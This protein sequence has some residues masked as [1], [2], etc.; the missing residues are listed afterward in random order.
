MKISV[1]AGGSIAE[2]KLR[3]SDAVAEIALKG[4]FMEPHPTFTSHSP[5]TKISKPEI[6]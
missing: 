3:H 4:R 5:R 1:C 2:A 6:L